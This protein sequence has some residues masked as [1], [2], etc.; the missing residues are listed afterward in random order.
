MNHRQ[1]KAYSLAAIFGL[2]F[3]M[4]H[5]SSA[6][7]Q[8]YTLNSL[9]STNQ[10][11]PQL[12]AFAP[13]INN[14]GKVAHVRR[15]NNPFVIEQVIFIHDGTSETPF[16][17][18]TT[19]GIFTNHSV[20]IND[21]DAIAVLAFPV[22]PCP[23]NPLGC[24]IR[25]NPDQSVTILAT[26][27]GVGAGGDFAEFTSGPSMNNSGQIAV[28]ARRESDGV[29]QII[30]VDGPGLFTE[31]FTQ[32]ATRL[33]P[34]SPSINNSGVVAFKAQDTSGACSPSNTC[35]FSG[36]GGPLTKEGVEPTSSGGGF[37]PFINNN[38]LVL[39]GAPGGPLI[40]TAQGGVVN[41]LV[42]G[43]EDPVFSSLSGQPSQND[44]GG[45]Y[46]Y[47][48]GTRRVLA[49][50][51]ETIQAKIRYFDQIRRCSAERLGISAQRFITLTI[52][53]RSLSLWRW[54]MGAET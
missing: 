35:V 39:A 19:A 46:S 38:G 5:T 52:Q 4:S 1:P 45:S 28:L 31:I 18:L 15:S 25:I 16:F 23:G 26:A 2:L 10:G 6:V 30:R 24:L 53:D 14:S 51:Q 44:L 20:V 32:T 40:Y 12:T 3:L 8:N 43:N 34:T 7:A 37:A 22:T 48:A 27:N 21:N 33:N 47:R 13:S 41:T 42:V 49:C 17:N 54:L 11:L 50:L 9:F 36:T 29:N